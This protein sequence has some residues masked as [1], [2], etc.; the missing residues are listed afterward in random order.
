LCSP[1]VYWCIFIVVSD[2]I[3]FCRWSFLI[4]IKEV[5][6]GNITKRIIIDLV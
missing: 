5:K 6:R 2:L 1:L 4:V 3:V